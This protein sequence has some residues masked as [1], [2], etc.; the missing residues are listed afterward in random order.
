MPYRDEL[1]LLKDQISTRQHFNIGCSQTRVHT[2]HVVLQRLEIPT[3]PLT[4]GFKNLHF[5]RV[6][7][8]ILMQMPT[9]HESKKCDIYQDHLA[10]F[11]EVSR[12]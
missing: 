12:G 6:P 3:E 2:D 8:V 7:G 9:K 1:T 4:V 11:L 5:E 10:L